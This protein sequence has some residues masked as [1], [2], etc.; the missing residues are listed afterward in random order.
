MQAGVFVAVNH[1]MIPQVEFSCRC[2]EQHV[3]S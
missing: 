2:N 3:F 1:K